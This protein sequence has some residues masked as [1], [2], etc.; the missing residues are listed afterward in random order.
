MLLTRRIRARDAFAASRRRSAA[1]HPAWQTASVAISAGA[2]HGVV[3]GRPSQL[4]TAAA[5]D[6]GSYSVHLLVAD[7]GTHELRVRYDESAHLGLGR[8]IDADGHLGGSGDALRQTL[9]GYADRARQLG[10]RTITVAGTDPLRRAP[11]AGRVIGEL[12]AATG[13]DVVALTHE[14][15]AMLALLGV[16]AGRPVDRDLV[17]VDVG[18]GSTEILIAG[19]RRVPEAIGL[20]LG[21]S[22]LT[23]VHV[24]HDPP[25]ASEV[26]AMS[27]EVAVAMLNAP[28]SPASQLVAVGGTARNLLRIGPQLG[29]RDLSRSR[30]RAAL[31]GMAQAPAATIAE[32]NGVRLSRARVLAAGAVILLGAMERYSLDRLRV[33]EGGLREGLILAAFHAGPTWRNEVRSLA[34]GWEA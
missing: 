27:A 32:R 2:K 16:Q 7:V 29:T 10:A 28:D 1:A 18:G 15:E 30:I 12:R 34:A 4:Q 22:R 13:L 11:D 5:I 26:G 17:M 20:P 3:E 14:E 31:D 21:A 25:S 23:G 24:E 9:I 6:I 19:P 33:A 8:T